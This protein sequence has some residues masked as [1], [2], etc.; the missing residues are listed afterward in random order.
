MKMD[1]DMNISK[2]YKNSIQK[3]IGFSLVAIITCILTLF[4]IYRYF[5]IQSESMREIHDLATIT[6]ERLAE[7]MVIPMWDIDKD[8]V[9]KTI[10]AYMMD[11]RIYAIVVKDEEEKFFQGRKRDQNWQIVETES[12]ITGNFLTKSKEIISSGEEFGRVN[13]E[14]LGKVEIYITQK[15]VTTDLYR[16]II[17]SVVTIVIMDIAALSLIWFVTLSIT[18][19]VAKIVKIADD[20]ANGDFSQDIDIRQPDE[21]GHLAD[22]F[23]NMKDSIGHVLREMDGL[24]RAVQ[25]GKLDTRG[26]ATAFAGGWRELVMGVNNVIN[27][28]VLPINMAAASLDRVSKGDIPE[29]ITEEYQGDFNKLKHNLNQLINA[30]H[31]ATEL[32]KAKK[33]AEAANQA[34][35]EF[36]SKM[37]HEL[38][39]P[40]NGILGYTQILLQDKGLTPLQKDALNIIYQ[41]GNHLLTLINDILDLSKVEAGKL[42][43]LPAKFHFANFL[44][45]IAGLMRLKAEQRHILFAY[46]ALTPL[47]VGVEADE[48][49]LRQV[50]INLLDNAVK[51]TNQGKVSLKVYELNEL[52]EFKNPETPKL[53]SSQTQKLPDSQTQK[54]SNTQTQKTRNIRFEVADTGIG[55]LPEQLEKIFLPFEQFG[56]VQSRT[57]GAG[58]GLAVTKNLV[59]LMGSNVQVKS[60]VGQGSIFWFDVEL[61]TVA[62]ETTNEQGM[63]RKIVGYKGRRL[64]VL[65]A[66]D[67]S[68]NR[69][70]L[71]NALEPLGFRVVVAENGQS[72]VAAAA[73]IRPDVILTDLVMPIVDGVEAVQQI[74]QMPDLQGVIIIGTSASVFESD[75]QRMILA[76]C[77]AF[78]AKPINIR[79]LLDVLAT[80]LKLEWI[81]EEVEREPLISA[82]VEQLAQEPVV[83]PQPEVL[84]TLYALT[85][86]GDMDDI[87]DYATQ[88]EQ[89]DRRFIPFAC[90]LREFAKNFQEEQILTLVNQFR[91]NAHS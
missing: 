6:I 61:P 4:G 77:D 69:S 70:M 43:I 18:R 48:K 81:Y 65:V 41:S 37:S 2:F 46:E 50:L 57:E 88:I 25:H 54:L 87:Q 83:P 68:S 62:I 64:T 53:L 79:Q 26:D 85:L 47:P 29:Q 42:E 36:L 76:G 44:D 12:E 35:S 5:V 67:Q 39:T 31:T 22:A 49:R 59:E 55:I 20:I 17:K 13:N 60:E 9:E 40:L 66:E 90:K 91:K 52:N 74:R 10:L 86:G 63:S 34:K 73:A 24:I 38:R 32:A 51:F 30:I 84:E 21:I 45:G 56:D 33:R 8:L 89:L 28:F 78:V 16:E 3:K 14:K 19:P 23:R 27:A 58:L 71:F 75:Q 82:T 72:E 1:A 7:H 80:Q 15:F 11:K